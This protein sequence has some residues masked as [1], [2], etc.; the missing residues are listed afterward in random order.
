VAA[1]PEPNAVT[2]RFAVPRDRTDLRPPELWGDAAATVFRARQELAS[3]NCFWSSFPERTS[4][5]HSKAHK[6]F[7]REDRET[8]IPGSRSNGDNGWRGFGQNRHKEDDGSSVGK[9]GYFP[10]AQLGQRLSC[11]DARRISCTSASRRSTDRS[12]F[13]ALTISSAT[14]ACRFGKSSARVVW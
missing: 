8:E 4:G 9:R 7:A 3:A 11:G 1:E 13:F 12:P 14:L 6:F 2:M 5:P 10:S